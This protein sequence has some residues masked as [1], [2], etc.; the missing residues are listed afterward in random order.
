MSAYKLVCHTEKLCKQC[1]VSFTP[2]KSNQGFCNPKCYKKYGKAH[3]GHSWGK[4]R[5]KVYKKYKKINCSKCGFEPVHL[6]QLDVDHIDGAH[7]NNSPNNLQTL[8][9]NCHR[10]KTAEQ[11]GWF[12]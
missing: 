12:K 8:C 2:K 6:C 7:N 5:T 1:S 10:L 11:L 9:S 4:G 3:L